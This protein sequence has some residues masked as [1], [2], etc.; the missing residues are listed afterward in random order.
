M[1]LHSISY[2]IVTLLVPESKKTAIKHLIGVEELQN[3]DMQ[4]HSMI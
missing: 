3:R 4:K 2:Q 1:L